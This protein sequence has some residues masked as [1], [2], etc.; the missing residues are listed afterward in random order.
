MESLIYD[1]HKESTP[2]V[3]VG[4]PV[5]NDEK[6]VAI[7]IEDILRQTHQNLEII[8]SDNHSTDATEDICRSYA[9]RDSRIRYI[10]QTVNSGPQSNCKFLLD[11]AKGEY[12]MWAASDDRWDPKFIS[13]LVGEL[14]K[15]PKSVVAFCPYIEI[16]EQGAIL[17]K[18]FRFDF[19]GNSIVRRITKFH[20]EPS[21]RRDAFFYGLFRRNK[22]IRMPFVSWWW[23]NK[24]M[25]VNCVFPTLS[26]V[27]ATG[28]YYLAQTEQPLW[29]NRIHRNSA[30]RH[31]GDFATKPFQSLFA[32]HLRKINQIY[33]TVRLVIKGSGSTPIGALLLPVVALR[34]LCDCFERYR[35]ILTGLSRKLKLRN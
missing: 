20:L 34:C 14:E 1:Q 23:I 22:V 19:F 28:N 25:P 29:Y 3:T 27:L 8:I 13:T 18:V 33:E 31:S 4:I 17:P 15:D 10:R 30:P 9:A 7:A 26:Y 2:L 32:F 11:Q 12:F 16:D 24:N 35:K 21:G 5:Y 6:Y